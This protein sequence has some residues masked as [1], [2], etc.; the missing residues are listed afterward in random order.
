[1]EF[2]NFDLDRSSSDLSHTD[3]VTLPSNVPY[4]KGN[5]NLGGD[6]GEKSDKE[7]L[8]YSRRLKSKYKVTRY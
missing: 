7:I 2:L 1:M 5:L 8:I 6:G 3:L 4:T